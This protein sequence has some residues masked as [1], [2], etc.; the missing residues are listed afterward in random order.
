MGEPAQQ[1]FMGDGRRLAD[2]GVGKAA[3][4]QMPNPTPDQRKI[5][6]RHADP[7]QEQQ[8]DIHDH[9]GSA[10]DQDNPG[11]FFN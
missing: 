10:A 4:E 2:G 8:P 3:V 1:G 5:Q 7:L 9:G 6:G 11:D